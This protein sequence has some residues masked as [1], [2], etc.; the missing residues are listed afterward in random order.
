MRLRIACVLALTSVC[1]NATILRLDAD[2]YA[3]GTNVSNLL[4]GVSFVAVGQNA[5][6]GYAPTTSSVTVA[7]CTGETLCSQ[8]VF[9]GSVDYNA[10]REYWSMAMEA[11]GCEQGSAAHCRQ[12]SF[13]VLNLFFDGG[14][15]H[16]A[17][18]SHWNSDSPILFAFDNAGDLAFR[19]YISFI[20]NC[21][22]SVTLN[23]DYSHRSTLGFSLLERSISRVMVGI[24]DGRGTIE[25][26]EVSVPEPGT[27][28]LFAS[29]LGGIFLF[30]RRRTV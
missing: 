4:D 27:L 5:S 22:Q 26:V 29:A 12:S 7:D 21:F 24:I 20:E 8:K 25:A 16:F 9:A 10:G 17:F 18:Q 2:D 28:A 11:Y 23:G 30:R 13:H 15:D 6:S 19:C 1:A 3:A 14:T